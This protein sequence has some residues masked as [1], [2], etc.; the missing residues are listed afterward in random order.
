[1]TF[2]PEALSAIWRLSGGT[3]RVINLLCDRALQAACTNSRRNSVDASLVE[4]A[5]TE[6]GIH[7]GTP[8]AAA[9]PA[10]APPTVAQPVEPPPI[11]WPAP[12]EL[13]V[14][15]GDAR[16]LEPPRE[17]SSRVLVI[18]AVVV[19]LTAVAWFAVRGFTGSTPADPSSTRGGA[20]PG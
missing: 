7:R 4:A 10:P 17:Q 18:A 15:L 5:A 3:P 16:D 14:V 20:A 13:P 8:A 11:V 2:G 1:M 19:V 9:L 12:D 6:L